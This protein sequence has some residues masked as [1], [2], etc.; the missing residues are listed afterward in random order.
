ML[1]SKYS[2]FPRSQEVTCSEAQKLGDDQKVI[3]SAA[4]VAQILP[5]KIAV[6][7]GIPHTGP[8]AQ[9]HRCRALLEQHP[10]FRGTDS[11]GGL[12]PGPT[13]DSAATAARSP[14][15]LWTG[16]TEAEVSETRL[17]ELVMSI[18]TLS[19]VSMCLSPRMGLSW[20]LTVVSRW[21][22]I[23]SWKT[24]SLIGCQRY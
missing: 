9:R 19:S 20:G 23:L 11:L 16:R 7:P 14:A 12:C 5:N 24:V 6:V 1:F 13:R 22:A 21:F 17:K 18:N 15:E 10:A 2:R 3:T 4:F 8:V